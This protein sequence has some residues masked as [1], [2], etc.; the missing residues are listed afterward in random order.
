MAQ[1]DYPSKFETS[2]VLQDGSRIF[3]R[4]IRED[5]TER[6]LNFMSRL[7]TY[8]KYLRF[9]SVPKMTQEDAARYCTVDYHNSF[10]LVA[11]I[12]K[13]GRKEIV[14]VGRY[15]RLP[16]EDS[17]EVAFLV[18]E[19]FQNKGIGTKLLEQLTTA[20]KE[21]GI[22]TFEADVLAEN[23]EKINV[24]TDYGFHVKRDFH[25]GEWRVAFP[26]TPAPEAAEKKRE[27]EKRAVT[28]SL[29]SVLSPRSVAVLG[30]SR[31]EGSIGQLILQ[32]LKESGYTGNVYPVNPKAKTVLKIEAY[33]SVLNIEEEIDLALIAV[34]APV[35][36]QVV[37]E[38][39]RKGVHAVVIVSDGFKEAGE[40]GAER[41][42]KVREI[43]LGYG[44]R[45][46]GPN[47]MGIM[48]MDPE[49]RL[50]GT[51]A[52][53][54]PQEG[55]IAFLSQSGALGLAMLE[56]ANRLNMGLSNFVSIGNR[57]DIS[58]NDL[59][60]YWEEDEKTKAILLYL[61]SF[62]NPQKFSRI[63]RR[64][65]D[66]KP[67][68]A[69]KGGRTP[70]G[71]QAAA[72]H[73]GAM[74]SSSSAIDA[75]FLE[76]G[77]ICVDTLEQAFGVVNLLSK[78]PV[79]AGNRVAIVTNGGGPG[80]MAADA[81]TTHGL[82]LEK[83]SQ[84]VVDQLGSASRRSI[85]ITNPL[86][87]TASATEEEFENALRILARDREND[88]VI[89]IS[90]PAIIVTSRGINKAL[91]QALPSYK[92][93]GK[94]LIACFVGQPEARTKQEHRDVPLFIFPE[95]AVSGLGYAVEYGKWL[96]KPKGHIPEFPHIKSGQA[97]SLV[98]AAMKSSSE[99]PFWLST[100]Q[101]CQ[102]LD[103]YGIHTT[104]TAFAGTAD[105]AAEKAAQIG[106]P[107]AVK[108]NSA[109]IAH[110]TEVG[111]I[112]LGI[113]TEDEIKQAFNKIRS[114]VSR[115]NRQ[116]E[117][118][119]VVVQRMITRGVE[120]IAGVSEDPT[121]GPLIMFG[122]G[123]VYTELLHDVAVRLHPLT[124][125]KCEA[126]I[127]SLRLSGLLKGWRGNPPSDIESLKDM[128]LRLS[129]LVEQVQEITEV[130]LNPVTALPEGEGYQVVD[131]KIRLT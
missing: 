107:V 35:V 55:N 87:L 57:A 82:V 96:K 89:L 64:V 42:Q 71:S 58:S 13:E 30:A 53:S 125:V 120:T 101:A 91:T 128:L 25:E 84:N 50:N 122:I 62:G 3:L 97:R 76:S 74:A 48:N 65:S 75:L 5:D 10:A 44:M 29:Q 18:E 21:N 110:K 22:S 70:A 92:E 46:V 113:E 31:K 43:A 106:F 94:T 115:E 66:R 102:L 127:D 17:A 85:S 103:C 124:D 104:D 69:I 119:G 54:F 8:T 14:A 80:I 9:H 131:P 61:E 126:M 130:D 51:F 27:K 2:T 98:D 100:P 7:G 45:V 63:A 112:V 24:F 23:E 109:T 79:P 12:M 33:S 1:Q 99:R 123:G 73:T 93:C 77:I 121:F 67:I 114:S 19:A 81:C 88:A 72:T 111:G 60:E 38:C 86:D 47:C 32:C 20:A 116:N 117:M 11:E 39:G 108:L 95:E 52:R 105:E 90:I 59:L 129:C 4:P 36:P 34:P 37:D 26:I 118:D 49:V 78:Q 56:Y 83:F 15:Q 41:E 40:E 68:I 6:W 16:R 28:A